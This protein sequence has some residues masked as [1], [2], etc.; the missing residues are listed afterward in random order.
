MNPITAL[1]HIRA[2]LSEMFADTLREQEERAYQRLSAKNEARI[3]QEIDR[4]RTLVDERLDHDKARLADAVE[5]AIVACRS[6]IAEEC[7]K[8][9]KDDDMLPEP[10]SVDDVADEITNKLMAKK[11]R[12]TLAGILDPIIGDAIDNYDFDDVLDSKVEDYISGS[13]D[14][15]EKVKEALTNLGLAEQIGDAIKAAIRSGDIDVGATVRRE[16]KR[17]LRSM[18]D[19]IDD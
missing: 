5:G 14:F 4:L 10:P 1:A 18:A 3:Q 8:R 11:Y 13:V 15:D 17:A 7:V 16:V 12:D 6:S 9:L 2:F 19:S